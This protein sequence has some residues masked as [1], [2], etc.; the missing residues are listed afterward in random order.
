MTHS[1]SGRRLDLHEP[2]VAL[3]DNTGLKAAFDFDD[4]KHKGRIDV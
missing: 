1:T 3:A 2:I 4:P